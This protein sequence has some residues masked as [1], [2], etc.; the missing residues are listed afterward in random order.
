MTERCPL[1]KQ[2]LPLPK[3]VSRVCYDCKQPIERYHKWTLEPR[4][5]EQILTQVHRNCEIPEA[6]MPDLA[7]EAVKALRKPRNLKEKD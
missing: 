1:C 4:G 2:K 5:S 7:C 3:S 6:Y